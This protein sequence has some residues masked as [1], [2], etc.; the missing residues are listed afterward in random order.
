MIRGDRPAPETNEIEVTPQ[1]IKVG[2]ALLIEYEEGEE[3][4]KGRFVSRLFRAMEGEKPNRGPLE[5]QR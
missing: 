1:M 5:S 4:D 3:Y 2:V